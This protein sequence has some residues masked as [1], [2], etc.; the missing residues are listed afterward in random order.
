MGKRRK[1]QSKSNHTPAKPDP[2]ALHLAALNHKDPAA[3][4]HQILEQDPEAINRQHSVTGFTP[5]ETAVQA[6]NLLAFNCFIQKG[7]DLDASE[8]ANNLLFY[9]G[10]CVDKN[11]RDSMITRLTEAP[12]YLYQRFKDGTSEF[13]V[14]AILGDLHKIEKACQEK[15]L[16]IAE[17]TTRRES[18]LNW[19]NYYAQYEVI[20]FLINDSGYQWQLEYLND[21]DDAYYDLAR[22]NYLMGAYFGE[23][24][25][26]KDDEVALIYFKQ[27][28]QWFSRMQESPNDEIGLLKNALTECQTRCETKRTSH[29]SEKLKEYGLVSEDVPGDGNCFFHAVARQLKNLEIE[30]QYTAE[31]LRKL[32]IQYL[33]TYKADFDGFC[34]DGVDAYIAKM[35]TSGNWADH[36]VMLALARAL[37]MS[38]FVLYGTD[39]PSAVF[40][41]ADDRPVLMLGYVSDVHF[42]SLA[43]SSMSASLT[44]VNQEIASADYDASVPQEKRKLTSPLVKSHSGLSV[45]T[46]ATEIID[47]AIFHDEEDD[48]AFHFYRLS[49]DRD[50]SVQV[51]QNQQRDDAGLQNDGPSKED[52]DWVDQIMSEALAQEGDEFPSLKCP[53]PHG[54]PE[55]PVLHLRGQ[56]PEDGDWLDAALSAAST[57]DDISAR[58]NSTAP[59]SPLLSLASSREMN[60]SV[61][62]SE[63]GSPSSSQS[64]LAVC[65]TDS[66]CSSVASEESGQRDFNWDQMAWSLYDGVMDEYQRSLES[67]SPDAMSIA[68]IGVR[69]DVSPP[70]DLRVAVKDV[71][72]GWE[73]QVSQA[74][75]A[76]PALARE[77]AGSDA[78]KSAELI[79]TGIRQSRPNSPAEGAASL[80]ASAN[81]VLSAAHSRKSSVSSLGLFGDSGSQVLQQS[82]IDEVQQQEVVANTLGIVQIP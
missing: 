2:D 5:V 59:A 44:K 50:Q 57:T 80:A 15:N 78:R 10:E 64:S 17:R 6:G 42:Q 25:K 65:E 75:D 49:D 36:V 7:A 12:D 45:A 58:G 1:P 24:A 52:I 72:E 67:K 8:C 66:S 73:E 79:P 46:A 30:Q 56:Q 27:A 39:E 43:A 35:Q 41:M 74:F 33:Q 38:L 51:E 32:A 76:L 29:F 31:A 4:I 62:D 60:G 61:C 16:K 21:D 48:E 20:K 69:D 63:C 37:N 14:A 13:H 22:A 9:A 54:D 68:D 11:R 71:D 34:D 81:S 55:H 23:M 47:P 77:L 26:E 19:A 70:D 18:V 82:E 40:K 3:V 28:L 53:A